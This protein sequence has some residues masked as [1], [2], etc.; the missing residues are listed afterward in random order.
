[1]GLPHWRQGRYDPRG[2]VLLP[3]YPPL[4]PTPSAQ[5][6]AESSRGSQRG[7]GPPRADA[8]PTTAELAAPDNPPT[9]GARAVLRGQQRAIAITS[10]SARKTIAA[11]GDSPTWNESAQQAS[12]A[13]D[14]ET[15]DPR[16]HSAP[17]PS[18]TQNRRSP[19]CSC[20]LFVGSEPAGA[21][22]IWLAVLLILLHYFFIVCRFFLPLFLLLFALYFL[23]VVEP[24]ATVLSQPAAGT[25]ARPAA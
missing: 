4:A 22:H 17:A 5:A 13:D 18:T 8:E 11:G 6:R 20:F 9:Q 3:V 23:L 10:C 7:P 15:P 16:L 14:P 21:T 1:M 24:G 25:P 12:P 19:I 2:G